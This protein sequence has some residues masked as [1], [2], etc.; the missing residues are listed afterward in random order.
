MSY[1]ISGFL[2]FHFLHLNYEK[3]NLYLQNTLNMLITTTVYFGVLQ[4]LPLGIHLGALQICP[5][6]IE[7]MSVMNKNNGMKQMSKTE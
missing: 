1:T 5:S 7:F 2:Y 6:L 3:F 4:W